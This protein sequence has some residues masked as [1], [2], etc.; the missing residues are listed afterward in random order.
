MSSL[1][2]LIERRKKERKYNKS[3]RLAH[4]IK[5]SLKRSV[6]VNGGQKGY[7][8]WQEILIILICR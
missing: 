6:L 2:R 8:F 4:L 5:E 7:E 3:D 1:A